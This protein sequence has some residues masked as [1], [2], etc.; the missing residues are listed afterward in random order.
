M[1]VHKIGYTESA[2]LLYCKNST[3]R[4]C[5]NPTNVF[6]TINSVLKTHTKLRLWRY[7]SVAYS[8]QADLNI[9]KMEKSS[10]K[11]LR[12]EHSQAP[13]A[14]FFKQKLTWLPRPTNL[15]VCSP[16]G[17]QTYFV[18]YNI[19]LSACS[20]PGRQT[21][22]L[23]RE[24]FCL[25]NWANASRTPPPFYGRFICAAHPWKDTCQELENRS[26]LHFDIRP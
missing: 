22:R 9:T 5:K 26:S 24:D 1:T 21:C 18:K 10:P 20:A 23:V 19:N 15:S 13:I 4:R 3:A 8:P 16:L 2:C 7:T 6:W 14:Q 12:H 17:R 11:S 25:K